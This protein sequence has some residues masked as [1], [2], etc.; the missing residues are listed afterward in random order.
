M[1][2]DQQKS[3]Y[4]LFSARGLEQTSRKISSDVENWGPQR[5]SNEL[6][7][8]LFQMGAE[9]LQNGEMERALALLNLATNMRIANALDTL[10]GTG[11]YNS[12]NLPNKLQQIS[13]SLDAIASKG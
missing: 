10:A 3:E 5:A 13:S 1:S 9:A 11:D 7:K 2:V 8:P 6:V 12:E 4:S